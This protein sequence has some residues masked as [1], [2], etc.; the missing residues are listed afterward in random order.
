MP[1]SC[2]ARRCSNHDSIAVAQM[3]SA[4]EI[5]LVEGRSPVDCN[6]D[7]LSA[8]VTDLLCRHASRGGHAEER[9]GVSRRNRHDNPRRRLGKER[10]G[11]GIF[12]RCIGD[13]GRSTSTPNPPSK[14]ISARATATPPSAQSCADESRLNSFPRRARAE[15]R[16]RGT[17]RA[18]AAHREF[19]RKRRRNSLPPS[20]FRVSPRSTTTARAKCA[21]DNAIRRLQPARRRQS[22]VGRTPRP[23]V[24]L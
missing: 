15:A 22:G 18:G 2:I 7:P 1:T 13:C 23:S 10:C 16:L 21:S 20:S 4:S 8:N 24:S 9:R 6:C 14:H 5:N 17:D 11:L 19:A 12:R 3:R